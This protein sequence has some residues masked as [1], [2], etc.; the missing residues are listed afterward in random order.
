MPKWQAT[1]GEK[2]EEAIIARKVPTARPAGAR[3]LY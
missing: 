3:G 1:P 2:A